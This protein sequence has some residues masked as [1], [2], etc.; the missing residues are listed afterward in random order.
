MRRGASLSIHA[1]WPVQ[2]SETFIENGGTTYRDSTKGYLTNH[3]KR[4][5]LLSFARLVL[6]LH[7]PARSVQQSIVADLPQWT[8]GH[9]QQN[10]VECDTQQPTDGKEHA[11]GGRCRIR[12]IIEINCKPCHDYYRDK[13][14]QAI[15]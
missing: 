11:Q 15:H 9:Q 3:S 1:S 10:E 5:L 2:L 4:N 13:D 6:I 14:D 7:P 12:T 8:K